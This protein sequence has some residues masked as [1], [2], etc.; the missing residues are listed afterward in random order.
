MRTFQDETGAT[1]VAGVRE[2]AGDDYKGR[3]CLVMA[4][5]G[6]RPGDE[7]GLDD[8]CW[9]SEKTAKRT[10][11]TMSDTELK[12]RLRSAAGRGVLL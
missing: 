6:G 11:L 9:N 4:Q 7:V 8:V 5:E 3:F 10:L 1:W 12:R 2:R